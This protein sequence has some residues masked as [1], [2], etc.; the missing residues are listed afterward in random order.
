MQRRLVR[1]LDLTRALSKVEPNPSPKAHLE[2]YTITPKA[3]AEIL[4]LAAYTYDDIVDKNVVDLGCGTGRLAI[5]SALLGANETVGVDID[6]IA[7]RRAFFNAERLGVN[8]GTQWL[9]ADVNVVRGFF[10]TVLQNPPFG[11]QKRKADRIFLKKAL[12]IG[13]HIYS[14]H[15]SSQENRKFVRKMEMSEQRLLPVSPS[16]FLKN[17]I[18][19]HGGEI[20]GVY[21]LMMETPYMFKFHKRRLYKYTADLYVIEQSA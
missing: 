1:K 14:L 16:P 19:E 4:Y 6:G 13:N 5:G 8:N 11:V 20:R 2:Q 10:D 7:T 21:T 12:E 18:L 9:T 17:F 3:A 15:H